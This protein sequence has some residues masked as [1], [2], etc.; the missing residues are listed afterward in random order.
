MGQHNLDAIVE[1]AYG[2]LGA[3]DTLKG[4]CLS[5]D[6]AIKVVDA[7]SG[8]AISRGEGLIFGG[9]EDR[10]VIK[11]VPLNNVKDVKFFVLEVK[12]N[13]LY[14]NRQANRRCNKI[15]RFL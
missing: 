15:R 12:K 9:F 14:R 7:K 1:V 5:F 13:L 3:I 11:E 10:G 2:R 6:V 4:W 8:K